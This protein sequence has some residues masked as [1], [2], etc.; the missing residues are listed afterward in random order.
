[1]WCSSITTSKQIFFWNLTECHITGLLNVASQKSQISFKFSRKFFN[2]SFCIQVKKREPVNRFSWNMVSKNFTKKCR[3][4]LVNLYL[5]IF[6]SHFSLIALSLP[7]TKIK[8][9]LKKLLFYCLFFTFFKLH[10]SGIALTWNC[11]ES[12]SVCV[13]CPT[14]DCRQLLIVET[15]KQTCH[16]VYFFELV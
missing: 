8:H 14:N 5:A 13:S 15:F 7:K 10:R 11:I 2:P 9:A 3:E 4:I 16:S 12:R 1:M 6:Y